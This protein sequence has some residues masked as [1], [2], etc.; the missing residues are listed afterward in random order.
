[1]VPPSIRDF[2]SR[3]RGVL[4]QDRLVLAVA[5]V[6]LIV[7]VI[8]L[9]RHAGPAN[10]PQTQAEEARTPLARPT[11][12]P[13]GYFAEFLVSD[14][15]SGARLTAA[16]VVV[17]AQMLLITALLTQRTRRRR[18]E[19]TL[20]AREATLLTSYRRI[21][22]LTGGL[23]YAEEAARVAMARDLHDDICQEMVGMAMSI[24]TLTQ[25]N[26]RIQDVR[27]Q[28]TLAKLHR[29]ALE[30]ADRVRRISH[31]LHPATLQLLGLGP[32]VKAHCLEVETRHKVSIAFHATGDLKRVHP[33]IG[34]CLFR[35]A[36]EALRNAVMHG[37]GRHL[38]VSLVRLGDD[39]EL[40]VHD[41]GRGFDVEAVRRD[42]RGLGLVSIEERGH[43][44]G[45]E[46][47]VVSQPGQGATIFACV[48]AGEPVRASSETYDWRPAAEDAAE[49]AN[50]PQ[51]Q[52]PEPL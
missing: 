11:S 28:Y 46:V 22:Q 33:D 43:A 42:G 48:P 34:L 13:L 5:T 40:T 49:P 7:A 1:M 44:A 45:G 25:S 31:E 39:I 6:A 4:S 23:I 52:T 3:H 14:R 35:I 2:I 32:A 18:A 15:F 21:R 12:A 9:A 16:V 47:M 27:T 19:E 29:Q 37:G 24:N 17:A 8:A 26:S 30:I 38:E 10:A 41:D 36:Q 50:K 20:R 51:P